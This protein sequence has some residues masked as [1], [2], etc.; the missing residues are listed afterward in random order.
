MVNTL[1]MPAIAARP[2]LPAVACRIAIVDDHTAIIEMMRGIV[3]SIGGYKVV[4]VAMN[5][6][7]AREVC[8]RLQPDMIVLDLVLPGVSGFDLLADLRAACPRTRVLIFS[9]HLKAATMREALTSGAFGLIEKTATLNEFQDALRAVGSGQ[10]YFSRFAGEVIRKIVHRD[11]GVPGPSAKLTE[12]E[13]SVLRAIADGLSSKEISARLGISRHTV[14]NHRT[15]LMKK[16][17]CRGV[18]LLARYALQIGLVNDT[19]ELSD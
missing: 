4:G 10:V 3:E 16:T 15:R 11:P 17:G 19:S 1:A 6:G 8:R 5:A 9:G 13:K 2:V 14:V 12:R 18:A 7:D